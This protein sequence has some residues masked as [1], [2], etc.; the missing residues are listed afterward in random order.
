MT[1]II[2]LLFTILLEVVIVKVFEK[3][4]KKSLVPP[5]IATYRKR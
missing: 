4:F 5:I 2:K 3:V 1:F